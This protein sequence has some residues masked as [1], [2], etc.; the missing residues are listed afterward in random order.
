MSLHGTG[1][2]SPTT[3]SEVRLLGF[4]ALNNACPHAREKLAAQL[5]SDAPPERARGAL[6]TA[7]WRLRRAIE[8]GRAD[9]GRFL[10]ATAGEIGLN[11]SADIRC[12]A[13]AFQRAHARRGDISRCPDAFA[14]LDSGVAGLEGELLEGYYDDWVILER[15]RL[16]AA[17]SRALFALMVATRDAGEYERALIYGRRILDRDPLR[18]SVH[19]EVIRL[20][21]KLGQRVQ[22]LRQYEFCT[23]IIAEELGIAPMPETRALRAEIATREALAAPK[24]H[25]CSADAELDRALRR[26]EAALQEL[27]LSHADLAARISERDDRP[28]TH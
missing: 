11:W 21:L 22:A 10:T 14:A 26:V 5:W 15:E 13:V 9:R 27:A 3:R 23:R 20:Y 28:V 16:N 12:D 24:T 7:L 17:R 18:E 25:S 2:T 19:R 4:L 8:P 6:K 1:W